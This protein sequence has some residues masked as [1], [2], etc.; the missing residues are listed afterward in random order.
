MCT[1]SCTLDGK[2]TQVVTKEEMVPVELMRQKAQ[3]VPQVQTIELIKE[4]PKQVV[5]QVQKSIP[6]YEMKYI[7]NVI[8]VGP[9]YMMQEEDVGATWEEEWVC[10]NGAR[11]GYYTEEYLMDLDFIKVIGIAQILFG[12]IGF[13]DEFPA[14][15]AEMKG[16]V[17]A[18]ILETQTQYLAQFRNMQWAEEFALFR[19]KQ[20]PLYRQEYLCSLSEK[21]LREYALLLF[22]TM[23]ISAIGSQVPA[24][25]DAA[26]VDNGVMLIEWILNAQAKLEM[27][28]AAATREIAMEPIAPALR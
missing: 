20:V 25:S 5:K 10:V 12:A 6:K 22:R 27:E 1:R 24:H 17:I 15:T 16:D 8:T 23:G 7:N 21:K 19:G 18:W 13:Q 3:Y 2:T 28:G 14:W 11:V 9:K 26:G 4:E